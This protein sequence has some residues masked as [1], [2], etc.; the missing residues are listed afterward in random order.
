MLQA[1]LYKNQDC[2]L[3]IEIDILHLLEFDMLKRFATSEAL[4]CLHLLTWRRL[5]TE[6][7]EMQ[8]GGQCAN[9]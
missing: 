9:D 6:D 5:L 8:C 1:K 3:N 2:F 4:L 7:H